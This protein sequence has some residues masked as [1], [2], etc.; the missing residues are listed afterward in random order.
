MADHLYK[1]VI[2]LLKQFGHPDDTHTAFEAIKSLDHEQVWKILG[3]LVIDEDDHLGTAAIRSLV[4]ID[5]YQAVEVLLPHLT[6]SDSS[7]RWY[8]CY[9]L[10]AFGDAR[11]VEPLAHTALH[12]PDSDV[13]FTAVSALERTGDIRAIPALRHIQ[14]HDRG[15]DYEGRRIDKMAVEAIEAITERAA[16]APNQAERS[17]E[18]D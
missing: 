8:I 16:Q 10:E 1:Q 9:V 6:N 17:S 4:G 18:E 11:S 13:R 15:T 3:E 12:D 5:A 7:I 2:D 14:L